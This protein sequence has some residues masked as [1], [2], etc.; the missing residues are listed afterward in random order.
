[1][2]CAKPGSKNL[3]C[4]TQ[5][6]IPFKSFLLKKLL[7][8]PVRADLFPT[9]EFEDQ[10]VRALMSRIWKGLW[11]VQGPS[12]KQSC[13]AQL[14]DSNA[15]FIDAV[16][17]KCCRIDE[18]SAS[19]RGSSPLMFARLAEDV[20][21]EVSSIE[22]SSIEFYQT[23]TKDLKRP[24]ISVKS[25]KRIKCPVVIDTTILQRLRNQS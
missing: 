5:R 9:V 8:L 2:V 13:G 12:N 20:A 7:N 1:M 14:S 16:A 17:A 10:I 21:A 22:F 19:T 11:D 24:S 3:S 18:L 6:V 25:Q 15:S 23:L 4:G